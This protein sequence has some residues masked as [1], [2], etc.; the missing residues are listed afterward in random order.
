MKEEMKEISNNLLKV[1]SNFMNLVDYF[2]ALSQTTTEN[3]FY[4]FLR[5]FTFKAFVI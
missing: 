2:R 3:F 1:S 5:S 4:N